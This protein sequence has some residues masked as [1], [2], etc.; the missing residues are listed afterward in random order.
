MP[1]H[2]QIS[3]RLLCVPRLITYIMEIQ[4]QATV[5]KSSSEAEYRALASTVCELQWL[6][7]LLHDFKIPLVQPVLLYCDSQS[8][9]HIASN[10]SFHER[11]KHIEI[12]CHVIREKLQA[13]L[14]HALPISNSNQLTDL[15]T[16]SLDPSPF[17][18][19]VHMRG[20]QCIH[21]PA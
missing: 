13:K 12:D 21:S 2:T 15:L 16:K 14:F 10:S 1:R 20:M 8:A 6:K 3:N 18:T 17:Q 7:Y 19:F 9:R 4:K 5:S 11:M